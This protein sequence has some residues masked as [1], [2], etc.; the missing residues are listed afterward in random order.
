VEFSDYDIDFYDYDGSLRDTSL[1]KW[2]ADI[3]R[4]CHIMGI[5]PC[6]GPKL[7]ELAIATGFEDV[8]EHVFELPTGGWPLDKKLVSGLRSY[9]SAHILSTINTPEA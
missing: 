2:I 9:S 5:E 7:K 4:S 6:P 1:A 3:L 8:V